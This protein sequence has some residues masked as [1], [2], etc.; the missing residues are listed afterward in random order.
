MVHTKDLAKEAREKVTLGE[1][2]VF[3]RRS[4]D[5]PFHYPGLDF[6]WNLNSFRKHLKIEVIKLDEDSGELEFDLVGVD[7]ALANAFRRIMI[8]EIPTMAIEK[9]FI[10]NNTS[11]IKD[12]ILAHRLGLIPI[13]ADAADFKYREDDDEESDHN[14]LVF[15]LNVKC[16]KKQSVQMNTAT[17]GSTLSCNFDKDYENTKVYSNALKWV[18]LG[19]QNVVLKDTI[20]PM[21]DDIL[22]VKMRPGQEIHLKMHVVK[23]VGK[24]HAKF[25]P[26]A[27][28]SYRLLPEIILKRPVFG[29]QA[30]RL[31]SCFAPGVI[32]LKRDGEDDVEEAFV[33]NPRKDTCTREV[34]NHDDLKELVELKKV[35]NHF[36]FSVESATSKTPDQLFMESVKIL[37]DKCSNL[38]QELN[39]CE[40]QMET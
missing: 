14:T 36:I 22:I 18:P 27:T 4:S 7:A 1:E 15:E 13:Q 26:V 31:Q 11:V 35:R 21:Q 19:D 10:Y 3:D 12:E 40:Q 29:D 39:N 2:Q 23:G 37:M 30:R 17:K 33:V 25:S 8:A 28:A 38:L 20:K 5:F 9:V 16:A 6:S 34:F 24:D 32:Q